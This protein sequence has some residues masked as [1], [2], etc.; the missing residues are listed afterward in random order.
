VTARVASVAVAS[1]LA[2]LF[3]EERTQE[4]RRDR[5]F[6]AASEKQATRPR[7]QQRAGC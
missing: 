7:V 4:V 5:G 1:V 3:G 6:S 2:N